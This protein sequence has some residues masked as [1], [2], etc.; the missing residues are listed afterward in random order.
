MRRWPILV[1]F[2][3][4]ASVKAQTIAEVQAGASNYIGSG[5]GFVLYGPSGETHFSA[6]TVNGKFVYNTSQRFE[7]RKW[8][9]YAGDYQLPLT[10][11]QLSLTAPVRGLSFIKRQKRGEIALFSGAL[12]DAFSSPYFFGINHA[13]MGAGFSFKRDVG[14]GF[15]LGTI[16]VAS[17]K[18]TSLEEIRWT[19]DCSI[20]APQPPLAGAGTLRSCWWKQH[21]EFRAQGGWLQNNKQV[22][23]T[24]NFSTRH[25]S[26]S[27]NRSTYIFAPQPDQPT[28]PASLLPFQR[29]TVNSGS[30]SG[31]LS[32]FTAGASLFQSTH[33]SGMNYSLG[34]HIGNFQV[35]VSDFNSRSFT[36]GARRKQAGQF[37]TTTE[38]LSLHWQLAQYV[39]RSQGTWNYNFGGGY[40]SNRLSAQVGY[41][42]LYFPLLQ[43]PFQKV[44]SVNLT[45]RIR[46]AS[47]N[48]GT[49][50]LPNGKVQW[51][52]GGEDYTAVPGLRLPSVPGA[53]ADARMLP[54]TGHGGKHLVEVFVHDTEGAPVEGAA[55]LVGPDMLYTNSQ[56][57]IS[58]RQKKAANRIMVDVNQFLSGEWSVV[59]APE[60]SDGKVV[61]IVVKKKS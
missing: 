31:G 44:L 30:L 55:V 52:T 56:G 25:V 17:Q 46:S 21:F 27:A 6:G 38:R 60:E 19:P 18:K 39:S 36:N 10:T 2:A 5:G 16:Q 26:A 43:H 13:H 42:L 35:N 49:I 47:M 14:H 15:T 45:F 28:S 7:F 34:M 54:S 29:V 40:T 4:A 23:G 20:G 32:L 1:L 9:V 24:A 59:S 8:E 22:G 48:V 37:L 58:S 11:G 50:A 57:H 33:S 3:F 53:S 51:T 61:E 41:N 12:G